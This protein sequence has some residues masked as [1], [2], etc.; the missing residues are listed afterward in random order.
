MASPVKQFDPAARASEKQAARQRDERAIESGAKSRAQVQSENSAFEFAKGQ[1]R[2]NVKS[3][4][5]LI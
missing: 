2:V 1:S 3:A 4:R 5:A